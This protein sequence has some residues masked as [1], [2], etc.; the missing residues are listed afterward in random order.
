[1]G[2]KKNNQKEPKESDE[3]KIQRL[4]EIKELKIKHDNEINANND[5]IKKLIQ[6]K[7]KLIQEKEKLIQENEKLIQEKEKLVKEESS[8]EAA[9][10]IKSENNEEIET[11]EKNDTINDIST[12]KNKLNDK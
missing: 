11:D 5:K 10:N 6:E 3:S 7:E 8:I 1:M 4:L 9:L 2:G 12:R